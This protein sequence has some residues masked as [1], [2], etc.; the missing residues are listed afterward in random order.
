MLRAAAEIAAFE[1]ERV[2]GSQRVLREQK[3]ERG[4][5][6]LL[7]DGKEPRCFCA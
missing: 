7:G 6:I 2:T 1:G 4:E 5:P 3:P